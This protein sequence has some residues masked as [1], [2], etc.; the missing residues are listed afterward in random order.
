MVAQSREERQPSGTDS[1]FADALRPLVD[2]ALKR[3]VRDEPQYW[4][5][6][7]SPILAPAI[8]VAVASAIRD[9]VQNIEPAFGKQPVG[10]ELAVAF[11]SMAHGQA[12]SGSGIASYTH[13]QGRAGT[14]G[15]SE[16]RS[17]PRVG[18]SL[19]C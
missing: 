8:R 2:T 10:T 3:S 19:G 1:R 7:I 17:S 12:A 18:I 4:A 5:Q 11:G 9:M 6:T 15:G 13:L 14:S 16:F